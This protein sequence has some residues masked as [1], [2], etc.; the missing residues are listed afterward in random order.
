[1]G[2]SDAAPTAAQINAAADAE[3]NFSAVMKRWEEIKKTDLAALNRQLRGANLPEI[4][5]E[6]N[7]QADEAQANM[8]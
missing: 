2:Q 4:N 6:S 7:G 1:V 8:E 3:H 5:L